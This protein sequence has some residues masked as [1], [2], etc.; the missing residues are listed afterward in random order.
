MTLAEALCGFSRVVL[1]HLDGRGLH[2]QHP[3]PIARVLEP[4]QVI[5]VVGEGMP[6]KKNEMK[7]DLYLI[8]KIIFPSHEWLVEHQV[9]PKLQELLPG[10]ER[11]VEAEIVDDVTYD[12][13][14]NLD[15]FRA[16]AEG[17]E[18]LDNDEEEGGP[19]CAQQ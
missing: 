3:Q 1:N 9:I 17:E 11:P 19:Q 4:G 12:E 18:W 8:V 14:A 2:L 5:K 6:Y 10:P 7:G 15:D 16:S 13:T